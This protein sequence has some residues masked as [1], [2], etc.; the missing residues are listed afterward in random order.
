[1]INFNKNLKSF[2]IRYYNNLIGCI[3]NHN[4]LSNDND[5]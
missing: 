3:Y 2:I 4:F 1:M 5:K